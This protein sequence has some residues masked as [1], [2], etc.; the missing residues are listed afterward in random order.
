MRRAAGVLIIVVMVLA[1]SVGT[2]LLAGEPLA[3]ALLWGAVTVGL[4]VGVFGLLFLAVWLILG[5]HW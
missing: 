4:V 3:S 1:V 2:P 5:G